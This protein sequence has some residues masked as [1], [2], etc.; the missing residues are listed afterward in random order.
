ML[1]LPLAVSAQTTSP[2]EAIQQQVTDGQ[3]EAAYKL[4]KRMPERQGD[5]HFDFLFGVAAINIGKVPEGVLA[6]ERHLAAV[7]GNDRA[8]LDLARGYFE[9]GDY[10]RARSEFE[11]VLRYNPPKE[12][13]SNIER[14]LDAMQ[15]RD[16]F[17]N[18]ASSQLFLEAGV[19][20]DSNVNAG[21]YNTQITLPTGPVVLANATSRAATSQ[22]YTVA[23]AG[24]WVRR[25]TPAFAVFG[26]GDFNQKSNPSASV[27]DTLNA[28][29][30]AGFSVVSGPVLYKLSVTEAM[31]LVDNTR[32]RD[33]LSATGEAQYGYGEGLMVNGVLQY[34]EQSYTASNS[35]RDSKSLTFGGGF[36][37]SFAGT[38]RPALGFQVSRTKED[39]LNRR[40]DLNRTT[41][42]AQ[43]SVAVNPTEQL[44][45][46]LGVARQH[47]DFAA[48]DIAFGTVRSD[49]LWSVD[50]S[51]NYALSR[52][53]V[54]RA[55]VQWSENA[56]NQDLYAFKRTLGMLKTRY[57]F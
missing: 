43:M 40:D 9:L 57:L 56:S 36:Q 20:H 39:N 18:K 3:Y 19:G 2:F 4:G 31:M 45:L 50:L 33:T 55:E 29:A 30:N 25:V 12:V 6:L 17:A 54:V 11:F 23:G 44:G 37:K 15:T 52:Q 21:T 51:A 1:V 28:A 27:F 34:A 49:R 14:Y 10:V 53:W 26:G 42:T 22:V 13:R 16:A 38:W 8:R 47:S 41:A 48:P 5:A 35:I 32:Y 24:Q 7:P 46:S